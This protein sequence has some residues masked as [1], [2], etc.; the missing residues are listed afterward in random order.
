M[1]K[2]IPSPSD[3]YRSRLEHFTRLGKEA[4]SKLKRLSLLRLAIFLVTLVLVYFSVGWGAYAVVLVAVAGLA[5]FVFTLIRYV[6][7]QRLFQAYESLATLN[8]NELR[9]LK[10]DCSAFDA[11]AELTDPDHPYSSDL[12]IFGEQ[13]VFQ[14]LNRSATWQGRQRLASWLTDPLLDAQ[15]I[16]RR[17]GAVDEMAGRPDMRQEFRVTGLQLSEQPTDRDDLLAWV[18]EPAEFDHWHFRFL[19]ALVSFLSVTVLAL[20]GFSVLPPVLLLLYMFVPF[21]ILGVYLRRINRIYRRLSH[22][23]ALVKKYS[24]LLAIL[25]KERF[26]SDEMESLVSKLTGKHGSPAEATRH[27]SGILNLLDQRN[28]MLMGFL[29]NFLFLWDILQIMRTE[30]WRSMHRGDLAGW[31][32]TVAETDAICSLANFRFNHPGSVFPMI[33]PEGPALDAAD[34]GHPLIPP[35]DRVDNPAQIPGMKHFTVITGANMAGKSTYLRTV[36][37]SLV[38]AM[39]GSAVIA[40]SMTFQ[41]VRLV[42]GIRTRDSLQKNES[43]FYAELKKLK[44]IMDRLSAGERLVILLDEIL[45]GTNSRDKQSGSIALVERLLRFDA[46]GFIATHDLALGELER[47]HPGQIN[48]KSFEVVIENDLLVFDYRLKDGIARQ[49]NATFLMKK[50][51]ITG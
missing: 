8:N 44:F 42:T 4:Q 13:G 46:A 1:H 45:K 35:K 29:L 21:G 12:D 50:M 24:G 27:L 6:H 18:G 51:G 16:R 11:G 37:V 5:A 49:M 33:D 22:K 20:V 41:P 34:L 30:R 32:E 17:Q 15:K 19:V 2:D 26:V 14:Y 40:R 36:G 23:S 31:L 10:G 28:N 48:N 39:A 9:A 7:L 47:D 43:Y 38:L 25:E 3:F